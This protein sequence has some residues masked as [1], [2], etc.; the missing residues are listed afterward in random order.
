MPVSATLPSV[1]VARGEVRT[2]AA[3]GG[4]AWS[5]VAYSGAP[6]MQRWGRVVVVLA[7]LQVKKPLPLLYQHGFVSPGQSPRLGVVDAA[8]IRA[9]GLHVSGRLLPDLDAM[10]I[11]D[12]ARAG[13]PFELSHSADILERRE[14][15][16]G[17][18]ERI[19]GRL[20]RGPIV[21]VTSSR[22]REV[23]IV[24]VG[25]DAETQFSIAA[26][27]ASGVAGIA[28][29]ADGAGRPVSPGLI[30][31]HEEL[32]EAHRVVRDI[33]ADKAL[34]ARDPQ[35]HDAAERRAYDALWRAEQKVRQLSR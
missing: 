10:K 18:E 17:Q 30:Q 1:V 7:G 21:V 13:F 25:A 27:R 20:V 5:G 31:A 34:A 14:L 23:S 29:T 28:A 2:F 6:F 32:A 33:N 26:S 3:Q 11:A 9:D 24:E 15:R 12:Q 19:N 8:E 35:E 16:D 4:S 22:L